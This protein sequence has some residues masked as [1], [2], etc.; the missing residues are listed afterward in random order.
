MAGA[1]AHNLLPARAQHHKRPQL[2]IPASDARWFLLSRIDGATVATSD[3]RGV[4]YR[5]RDPRTFWRLLGRSVTAHV[6]LAI[7]WPRLRRTYRAAR[8]DLVSAEAWCAVFE[9]Q[10]SLGGLP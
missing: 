7:A 4:A 6:R 10:R 5:K 9:R 2:N 1:L 3:G 8:G